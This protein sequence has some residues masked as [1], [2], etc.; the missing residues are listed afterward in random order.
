MTHDTGIFYAQKLLIELWLG[1]KSF[2]GKFPSYILKI[3]RLKKLSILRNPRISG[4][5]PSNIGKSIGLM[6]LEMSFI[7]LHGNIYLK[8]SL[9][10]YL[11]YLDMDETHIHGPIHADLDNMHQIKYFFVESLQPTTQYLWFPRYFSS[12]SMIYTYSTFDVERFDQILSSYQVYLSWKIPPMSL[13][14]I[15]NP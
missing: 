11:C 4:N 1:S 15:S 13:H 3:D 12:G 8:F 10:K 5:V 7:S 2:N 14:D 9:L 6:K